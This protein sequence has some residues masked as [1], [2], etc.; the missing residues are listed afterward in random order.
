MSQDVDYIDVAKGTTVKVSFGLESGDPVSPDWTCDIQLR[1]TDTGV[2]A[3]VDRPETT[4]SGDSLEFI[5]EL[6]AS[7][8]DV[9]PDRY[10]LA[11]ELT[12]GVTGEVLEGLQGLNICQDWVHS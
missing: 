9:D 5:V 11:A 6:T 8:T 4:V 7:E 1:N 12:N 10:M 2:L 3:G